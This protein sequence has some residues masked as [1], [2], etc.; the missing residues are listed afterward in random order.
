MQRAPDRAAEHHRDGQEQQHDDGDDDASGG[1]ASEQLARAWRIGQC[2]QSVPRSGAGSPRA[3]VQFRSRGISWTTASGI[4]RSALAGIVFVVLMLVAGFLPGSPP[5]PSDSAAKIVKFVD[6]QERPAPL[7]RVP[8]RARAIVLLGWLGAVWRLLRRAE[9]GEPR[10][11]VG[12]ALGAAMA[13]ALFNAAGVLDEHRRHRR[14]RRASARAVP[15]SST[16]CSAA[17][18]P[19]AASAW[20]C[21]WVRRLDRDHPDAACCHA[22]GLVRRADRGRAARRGRRDRVDAR[23]VLR[24]RFVGFIG[25]ALWMLIASVMMYR[26]PSRGDR[27]ARAVSGVARSRRGCHGRG[28]PPDARPRRR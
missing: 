16:C 12:A 21:S 20:R 27:D 3:P 18:V 28:T 1:H 6:R 14:R 4:V 15:G 8:R 24:L 22:A 9:G 11:A 2:L 23:R 25:F 13:A 7:G 19:P 5:K 10:L 17:S 26:L